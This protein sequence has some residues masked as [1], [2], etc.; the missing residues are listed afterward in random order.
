V[1]PLARG[2][3]HLVDK[4]P[5]NFLYAGLIHLM[6]P[7]ARIIH[8]RRDPID[9]CLSCY[10]KLFSAE[11]SFS[12]DQAE[13]GRFYRDY[14]TLMAHWRALL[15]AD[16]FIEVDYEQVVEDPEG[17]TR[18]LLA[19]IGL[20]WDEACLHF[21]ENRRAVRTASLNQVRQPIFKSSKGRWRAH[22]G[23]LGPLM[24][25]LGLQDS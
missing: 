13:L 7:E 3:P 4:M 6:L 5:A 25:A 11:Q 14:Q 12:Y 8:C 19:F 2:K 22:A 18:R 17:E 9:T 10:S 16:R 21:H 23:N 1:R 24:A 15:P 20:P